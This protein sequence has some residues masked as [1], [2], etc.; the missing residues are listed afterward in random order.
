MA[1]ARTTLEQLE[2]PAL[3]AADLDAIS[4]RL[5]EGAAARERRRRGLAAYRRAPA[6]DPVRHLWRFTDFRA[7]L[8]AGPA[9]GEPLAGVFAGAPPG[10]GPEIVLCAGG[11]P[12]VGAAAARDGVEIAPLGAAPWARELLGAAVADDHGLFEALNAAG[13][14]AGAA[15]RVPA[16]ARLERPLRV[17]AEAGPAAF[18]PRLLVLVER[19]AAVTVIE[20]HRGGGPATRTVAVTELFLQPGA[21]LRHL[22]LQRWAPAA[23]GH[24]TLR[25]RVERDADLL[26]GLGLLGG[27]VAKLDVGADLVG[28]GARSEMAGV[29]LGGGRQQI[30]LHT[31]HRHVAGATWSNLDLKAVLAGRARSAYTGLIRIE[32]KAPGS[33]AYQENRNLLLSRR[34]HADTIPE[35]EILTDEVS[36][37]HGA[38]VA[39]LDAEHLF[40]LR[41]R[42]IPRPQA[43]RLVV[44]GF[45]GDAL[46]R[47]PEALRLEL[48]ALVAAKLDELAGEWS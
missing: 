42:G 4:E 18:L 43:V 1:E 41:S 9:A 25:G 38:T 7:L 12:L 26:V 37:T 16:G 15:V 8:P 5:G 14:T 21:S 32:P 10:A 45:L 40:Y 29:M 22:L 19:G 17:I 39:P 30:D 34:A 31:E 20:E 11:P 2:R 27:S 3:A 24:L 46:R 6:P 33:E 13:W 47:L 35:L 48:E 44:G 28:P 23:A 36:C